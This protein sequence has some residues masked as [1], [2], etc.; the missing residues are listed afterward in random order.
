[1][2]NLGAILKETADRLA[3]A[4]IETARLDARLLVCHATGV[5][6]STLIGFPERDVSAD[7]LAALETLVSL[8][9]QRKPVSQILGS[10]EFW[11]LDF[12]VTEDTL[13]PRPD[14]ETLIDG[15]LKETPDDKTISILDLGTGTGCILLSLL[16]DLPKATG[17][18]VDISPK[19]L[20]VA[21]QNAQTLK[22]AD[23]VCFK[24]SNWFEKVTGPFDIIVSNPPYI[25]DGDIK[26]LEDDV[27]CHE[28]RLALA[29]GKDGLDCYRLI[30]NEAWNYL[31]PDG[32][33]GF[34]IGE[35]QDKD[36]AGLL[37]QAGFSCIQTANDLAG[38]ARCVFARKKL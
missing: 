19:A 28:P 14:T 10:K 6:L 34:E 8:R 1:M 11:S 26:G 15:V 27:A 12:M 4:G 2:P 30:V 37:E 16:H 21:Q 36:I 38:I 25:P 29:G 5:E 3:K 24:E 35:G 7:Q 17:V 20:V 13:T 32:L 33:I 31:K 18:G 22:L 23:R 9:E